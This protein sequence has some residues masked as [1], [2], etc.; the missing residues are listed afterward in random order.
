MRVGRV[1]PL[2]EHAADLVHPTLAMVTL[3]PALVHLILVLLL[4][5]AGLPIGSAVR[6]RDGI[7][8]LTIRK[9]SVAEEDLSGV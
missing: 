2:V 8:Q 9:A 6:Q 3:D 7:A 1:P 4:F 5:E